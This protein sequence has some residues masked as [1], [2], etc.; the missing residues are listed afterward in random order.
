M[1]TKGDMEYQQLA[2]NLFTRWIYAHIPLPNLIQLCLKARFKVSKLDWSYEIN[3]NIL[4]K[5]TYRIH[6]FRTVCYLQN[7]NVAFTITAVNDDLMISRHV[8]MSKKIMKK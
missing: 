8:I 7:W 5:I 6:N 4:L 2:Y 1:N 3:T